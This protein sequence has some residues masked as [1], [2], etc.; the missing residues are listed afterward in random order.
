MWEHIQKSKMPHIL[1]CLLTVKIN[2]EATEAGWPMEELLELLGLMVFL[3]LISCLA[4][5][6]VP[7]GTERSFPSENPS[8]YCWS[9]QY[10]DLTVF[11]DSLLWCPEFKKPNIYVTNRWGGSLPGVWSLDFTYISV[12]A[13]CVKKKQPRKPELNEC[14]HNNCLCLHSARQGDV[15]CLSSPAI[16]ISMLLPPPAVCGRETTNPDCSRRSVQ[17]EHATCALKSRS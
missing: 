5:C 1:F 8:P 17:S 14:S 10:L 16:S 12:H 13:L 11:S 2:K 7:C 15:S 9:R 3:C 6:S 4:Q